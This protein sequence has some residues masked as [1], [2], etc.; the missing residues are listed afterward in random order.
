MAQKNHTTRTYNQAG[1]TASVGG[2]AS[3]A[4]AVPA[5]EEVE[6]RILLTTN[7]FIKFG[8]SDV[9]ATEDETSIGIAAW[10]PEVIQAPA[11]ATH[12]SVIKGS[13]EDDGDAYLHRVL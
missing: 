5:G 7:G 4:V 11:D 3:T 2:S 13:G 9:A 6:I 12:F 10:S 1:A 8:A